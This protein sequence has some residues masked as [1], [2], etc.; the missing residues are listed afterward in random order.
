MC[1]PAYPKQE[2]EREREKENRML[3]AATSLF[4]QSYSFDLQKS[5]GDDPAV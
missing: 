4:L 3:N 5:N 1:L 2:R